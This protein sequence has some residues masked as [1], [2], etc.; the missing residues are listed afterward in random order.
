M[1]DVITVHGTSVISILD[2]FGQ[3]GGLYEILYLLASLFI[4]RISTI[5]YKRDI[6]AIEKQTKNRDGWFTYPS[7]RDTR[8]SRKRKK[9]RIRNL[10]F[11]HQPSNNK[12]G[13]L[14]KN[15]RKST[16]HNID[17]AAQEPKTSSKLKKIESIRKQ[18]HLHKELVKELDTVNISQS[19]SELKMYVS[20]L[21]DKD[22]HG[23]IEGSEIQPENELRTFNED[24]IKYPRRG[25]YEIKQFILKR[26][27]DFYK[28]KAGNDSGTDR[29]EEKQQLRDLQ[30]DEP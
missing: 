19:L 12:P 25:L 27:Q 22:K 23:S 6:Q 15:M 29:E 18:V 9:N 3:I 4:R 11:D 30:I 24:T 2:I 26:K 28:K 21:L 16:F 1:A 13:S 17:S 5:L 10:Q 14:E 7:S 8:K 20:Y